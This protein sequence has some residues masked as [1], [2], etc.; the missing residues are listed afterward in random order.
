MIRRILS[1]GLTLLLTLSLAACAGQPE[2]GERPLYDYN[3]GEGSLED[4]RTVPYEMQGVIGVPEGENR[5]VAVIVHG[6][7]F[8]ETA[9]ANRYD[10][11]FSYLVRALADAGYLAIAL[12]VNINYSF[13]SGEP[14]G[15]VRTRQILQQQLELLAQA[16]GGK[17][18]FPVDLTG[19]GDL[20]RTVL[21]G[22]SRGGFDIL[23]V[24]PQLE[25]VGVSGMLCVAASEYKTLDG[26][27]PDVPLS[28]LIPQYDGDVIDLDGATLYET[29]RNTPGRTAPAELVYLNNSDHSGF[30]EAL[31]EPDLS[32]T[33]AIQELLM[34]KADQRQFLADYAVDFVRAV[35]Q[36]GTT[37]LCEAEVLPATLFGRDVV[38]QVDAMDAVSVL[39]AAK[40]PRY[41]VSQLE[42]EGVT[43]TYLPHGQT[44]G[45]FSPPGSFK[46]LS[47]LR[48]RWENSGASFTV[49]YTQSMAD[50]SALVLEWAID[51]SD[52][53]NGQADQQFAVVL[54]DRSGKTASYQLPA[55]TG[56]LLWQ[57]G[58]LVQTQDFE[59]KPMEEYS[60]FTPLATTRIP[61]R[62]FDGV[63]LETPE[64]ILL[65]PLTDGGSVMLRNIQIETG[66]GLYS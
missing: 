21:I 58:A 44:A 57:Q 17:S 62:V 60:T 31:T 40:E 24:G 15:N 46:A 43:V 32:N 64:S 7:H 35:T 30:N 29:T 33:P 18:V 11:G 3:L 38:V 42:A 52:P 59:G 37:P 50:G 20:S 12:N 9:A 66:K 65:V 41:G 27:V 48:L 5:P 56:A 2:T 63:D 61:L 53:R 54:T 34:P 14:T 28:F 55:D 47:L 8:I 22:H 23:E 49:P 19:K 6:S 36:R 10:L 51:S 13:E 4:G 16:I 45:T 1:L 26:Q 25:N 39:D